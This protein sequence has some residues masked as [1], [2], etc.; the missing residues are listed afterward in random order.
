MLSELSPNIPAWCIIIKQNSHLCFY[1][2]IIQSKS[3]FSH[4]NQFSEIQRFPWSGVLTKLW[5]HFVRGVYIVVF[6]V[7][8]AAT[9]RKGRMAESKLRT[10]S[11][12]PKAARPPKALKLQIT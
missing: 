5:A 4:A 2:G 9:E 8:G 10:I 12:R 11:V 6:T 3:P 1:V 7:V